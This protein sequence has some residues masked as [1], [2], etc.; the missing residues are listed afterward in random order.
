MK[1]GDKI[2]VRSFGRLLKATVLRV[3][4]RGGDGGASIRVRL[5]DGRERT[6]RAADVETSTP[7]PMLPPAPLGRLA[8]PPAL[9]PAPRIDVARAALASVD[10]RPIRPVP[11]ARP[12]A[13]SKGYMEWVRGKPCASCA[14]GAPSEAHHYGPR[15]MGSKTSDYLTVPLCRRCHQ[16]FHDSGALPGSTPERTREAFLAAQVALLHAWILRE[17]GEP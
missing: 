6:V 15:G 11:K 14:A 4:D 10:P 17:E 5:A 7:T 2:T 16:R 3:R 9:P 1:P 12:A 8:P 13:R